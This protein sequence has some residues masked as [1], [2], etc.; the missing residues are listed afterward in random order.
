MAEAQKEWVQLAKRHIKA[1]LKRHDVGYAE[2]A[3]LLTEMGLPYTEGL[4]R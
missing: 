3:E 4:L 2:L 1:T